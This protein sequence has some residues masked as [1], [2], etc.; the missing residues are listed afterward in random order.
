MFLTS[1]SGSS[2]GGWNYKRKRLNKRA[3]VRKLQNASN[4]SQKHRSNNALN[5]VLPSALV[6]QQYVIHWLQCIQDTVL[7][8][9]WTT[10]GGLVVNDGDDAATSFGLAD[11]FL[12]GGKCTMTLSNN[13]QTQL[14]VRTW[15]IRTTSQ[16]N[17]LASGTI[18]S[19]DWD[20]SLP[21]SISPN[22]DTWRL[23]SFFDNVDVILKPG[24]SYERT[25][26]LPSRRIDQQAHVT[27]GNRDF[28]CVAVQNLSGI[29][30]S[31]ISAV[32]SHNLTFTGDRVI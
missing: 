21:L 14:K 15:R 12:R 27:L 5:F 30:A 25:M 9:F 3:Y 24:E 22:V 29:G 13:T 8:N 2:A 17:V 10:G 23:Y 18:V 20:P 1:T 6:T 28:W 4:D 32:L 26:I 19:A 31:S 11:L 16:G 7:N